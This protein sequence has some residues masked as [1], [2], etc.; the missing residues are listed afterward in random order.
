MD[1]NSKD[2]TPKQSSAAKP[3]LVVPVPK[4]TKDSGNDICLKKD[5]ALCI[6]LIVKSEASV[7]NKMLDEMNAVGQNFAS[8]ISRGISFYFM[9]VDASAE[10]DFVTVFNLEY[11]TPKLVVLNP[12]KRKRFLLH[13]GNVAE[14]EIEKTLDKILGGDARFKAI[15]GKIPEL[16]S[17][18]E[19]EG[20]KKEL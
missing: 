4:L 12:G 16:V 8:K 2:N 17:E 7:D 6:I 15:K 14:K 11:D 20:E 19:T 3:W 13:E 18:Y 10:K 5:G 9:W 1:P